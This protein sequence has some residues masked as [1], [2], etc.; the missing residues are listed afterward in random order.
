[1]MHERLGEHNAVVHVA[2]TQA[3]CGERVEAGRLDRTAVTAQL[4]E[5]R[6]I[7][8]DK[9]HIRRALAG[10]HRDRPRRRGLI[11]GPPDHPG[12]AAPGSYSIIAI[13]I[14]PAGR[15]WPPLARILRSGGGARII[16]HGW[17]LLRSRRHSRS[18]A[19]AHLSPD[20]CR[21]RWITCGRMTPRSAGSCRMRA[22]RRDGAAR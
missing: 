19:V 17:F 10:P 14:S 16:R 15:Y 9:Q 5:P 20:R 1:M 22:L 6:I 18:H 21:L 7:Q 2:I 3:V 11:R 13:R 4:P 12:N 8:H